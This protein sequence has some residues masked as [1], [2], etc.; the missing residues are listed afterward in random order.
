MNV[1]ILE[2]AAKEL[3]EG[4]HYYDLQQDELGDRFKHDIQKAIDTIRTTPTLFPK[5]D[6]EIRKYPLHR[7][8]YTIYYAID[9]DTLIVLAIAHQRRKPYYWV[10]HYT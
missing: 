8:P 7:F 6:K 3:E 4:R 1:I 10:E 5:I 9:N 2:L